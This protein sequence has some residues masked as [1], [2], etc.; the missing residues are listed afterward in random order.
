M[1]QI[2]FIAVLLL[3]TGA[4]SLTSQPAYG[5][6]YSVH[7]VPFST[8]FQWD[9]VVDTAADTL[10]ITEWV[11]LP[12]SP[13]WTLTSIPLTLPAVTSSRSRFDVP[14]NW[15]GSIGNDWAFISTISNFDL[16]WLQGQPDPFFQ[17]IFLGWNGAF[18][19]GQFFKFQYPVLGVVQTSAD[20]A[21]SGSDGRI[22][23]T[24][25]A[26]MAEPSSLSLAILASAALFA[27][28]RKLRRPQ[29]R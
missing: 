9:G 1:K 16:A 27:A 15:D 29:T 11:N 24:R 5:A 10:T 28:R 8:A 14:D 18:E 26:V 2:L 25:I 22:E 12:G 20:S 6:L 4:A 19:G 7:F 13:Y 23:I 21:Q 17:D 3:A